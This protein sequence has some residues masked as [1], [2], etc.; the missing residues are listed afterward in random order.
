MFR[1]NRTEAKLRKAK[2]LSLLW[3][4]MTTTKLVDDVWIEII[5]MLIL[6]TDSHYHY[7]CSLHRDAPHS[8]Q[9]VARCPL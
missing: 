3:A 2:M 4:L 6:P 9:H 8:C 5:F 1:S 7:A